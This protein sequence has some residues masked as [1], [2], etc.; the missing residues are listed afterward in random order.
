MIRDPISPRAD[1]TLTVLSIVCFSG[2]YALLSA[3]QHHVNPDDTTLPTFMQIWHGVLRTIN[4]EIPAD[5]PVLRM[6]P[7]T[8]HSYWRAI[9]STWL[10]EDSIATFGRLFVGL[11]LSVL[12]SIVL[13]IGM[14]CFTSME[15]F[16]LKPM[17][18]LA[19]IP[20]TA[21]I[22]VFFVLPRIVGLQGDSEI[23]YIGMIAAGITPTL[24][25]AIYQATRNDVPINSIYKTRTLGASI[26]EVIWNHVFKQVLPRIIEST[27]LSIGPAMVYLLAAEYAL[28]EVGFGYRLRMQA[29]LLNM[30]VVYWYLIL[31]GLTGWGLDWAITRLRR[32]WCPWFEGAS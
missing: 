27:R 25:Q 8:I 1:Y 7:A 20:P 10:Y 16:A 15:S 17:S 18:F 3:H 24:S 19:K 32:W 11:S 28:A 30:S 13:G 23:I 21:A 9:T 5:V 29:R 2:A 14:G 31:L 12:F 26:P 22:P 4:L 6:H